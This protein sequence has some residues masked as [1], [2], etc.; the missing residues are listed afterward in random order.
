MMGSDSWIYPVVSLSAVL[1]VFIIFILLKCIC[2]VKLRKRPIIKGVYIE[3]EKQNRLNSSM[4]FVLNTKWCYYKPVWKKRSTLYFLPYAA[5]WS[6][7]S[8]FLSLSCTICSTEFLLYDRILTLTCGH[9]CHHSC[10]FGWLDK[11]SKYACPLCLRDIEVI[12]LNQEK[13]RRAYDE[14][15]MDPASQSMIRSV[16]LS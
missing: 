8:K 11:K 1:I 5:T 15:A 9:S 7:G 10:V 13:K 4:N 3:E 6:E 14:E 2:K 16:T 12:D